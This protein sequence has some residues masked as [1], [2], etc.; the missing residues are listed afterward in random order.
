[1]N[2]NKI[3]V[4]I[5]NTNVHPFF[6]K[7]WHWYNLYILLFCMWSDCIFLKEKPWENFNTW[8]VNFF[9]NCHQLNPGSSAGKSHQL[10]KKNS[11]IPKVSTSAAKKLRISIL[12]GTF[13]HCGNQFLKNPTIVERYLKM[14]IRLNSH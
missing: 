13:S 1:M 12:L 5:L 7:K 6:G 11:N 10:F 8:N 4:Y 2:S 9:K 3:W 14:H